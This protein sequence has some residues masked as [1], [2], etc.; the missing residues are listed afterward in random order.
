[1]LDG[2]FY[3]ETDLTPIHHYV[4]TGGYQDILWGA[5]H[6]LGFSLEPRI[7]DIGD[8]RLFRM[9]RKVDEYPH[10][11]PLFTDAINQRAVRENWESVLRAMA[12][13]Y[14]GVV[15]AS[16]L[17]RKLSAFQ[18]EGGLAK[19]LLQVGRI[20]KTL[21]LLP[22]FIRRER[23]QRVQAGLNRQEGFHALIGAL[24]V[25]PREPRL[26]DLADQLNRA[27]CLQLLTAMVVTWNGLFRNFRATGWT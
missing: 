10:I 6:L 18:P 14:F 27:S 25:G 7:R 8:M 22:Y 21:H 16:R 13:I 11:A 19:A 26:R 12:S 20:A 17:L 23:R 9:R 3:H 24:V 5:C 4:D 1:M 2:L 15:P